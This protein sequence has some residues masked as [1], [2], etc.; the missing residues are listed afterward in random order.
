[1]VKLFSFRLFLI[2][3][4]M[5]KSHLSIELTD[6]SFK[7]EEYEPYENRQVEHPTS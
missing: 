5:T 4:N 2:Y 1:M 3:R 6:G 7:E